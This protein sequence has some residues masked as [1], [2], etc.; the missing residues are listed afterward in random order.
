MKVDDLYKILVRSPLFWVL[1]VV[2]Y[3][4]MVFLSNLAIPKVIG[5]ITSAING[6]GDRNTALLWLGGLFAGV[7]IVHLLISITQTELRMEINATVQTRILNEVF[8]HY[9][10]DYGRGGKVGQAVIDLYQVPNACEWLLRSTFQV[11]PPIFGIVA[12]PVA[13]VA[14]GE[15]LL[16]ALI[17]GLVLVIAGIMA[18]AFTVGMGSTSKLHEARVSLGE[19]LA[20]V[21]SQLILVFSSNSEAGA[22]LEVKDRQT[23]LRTERRRWNTSIILVQKIVELI[24][25]AVVFYVLYRIVVRP[26]SDHANLADAV[27]LFMVV[28]RSKGSFEQLVWILSDIRGD[29]GR[30]NTTS[31][32]YPPNKGI[33]D[34]VVSVDTGVCHFALR[35]V[36]VPDKEK[37]DA[38]PIQ[39][40]DFETAPIGVTVIYGAVGTGK[41]TAA[42]TMCGFHPYTGSLTLNGIEVSSIKS[43]ELR[44][45]VRFVAQ[46]PSLIVGTVLSNMRIGNPGMTPD[47]ATAALRRIGG[48]QAPGIEAEIAKGGEGISGGQRMIVEIARAISTPGVACYVFD[49]P[50]S[51]M[52]ANLRVSVV[53]ALTELGKSQ[54]VVVVSHHHQLWTKAAKKVK[55]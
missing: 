48:E 23:R 44:R 28:I 14:A 16:A 32:S 43:D 22:K 8:D 40:P 13:L 3:P 30:L 10:R 49:E 19:Y 36:E 24:V 12:V 2:L 38:P 11:I 33:F 37:P 4:S 41:S 1:L 27:A 47:Q 5:S 21:V 17:G 25:I 52:D 29:A 54:T 6:D 31:A 55:F 45:S 46:M 51:N 9:R 42:R 50:T 53:K 34:K 26:K 18:L 35:G 15:S 7:Y 20:D 39:L